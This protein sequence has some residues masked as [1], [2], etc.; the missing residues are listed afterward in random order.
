MT[1]EVERVALVTGATGGIGRAT[2]LRLAA[3]GLHVAVSDRPEQRTELDELAERI[4]EEG[5]RSHSLT[6]DV[7][8]AADVE[9]V[10]AGTAETLGRLDVMVANAGVCE[11]SSLLDMG[12]EEWDRTLAVNARGTFLSYQA[13]ARQMIRQGRGGTIVGAA[14]VASY[15]ASAMVGHYAASKFAVRALTEAAALEW[16]EHGITVNAYAPG[17]VHTGMWDRLDR[18]LGAGSGLAPG[19][20]IRRAVDRIPLGRTQRPEDVAGLVSYLVSPDAGY[21]T[22]QSVV[23]DG[24]LLLG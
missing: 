16:A 22:G 15:G 13:A 17:L 6:G 18:Q 5:V 9:G 23:M 1:R 11:A 21:M 20:V 8:S 24:G 19:E 10:V 14:S 3:D 4:R 12:P 2:A 7:T